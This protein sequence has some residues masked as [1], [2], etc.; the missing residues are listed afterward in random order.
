MSNNFLDAYELK[1]RVAPGLILALPLIAD[2]VYAVPNLSNWPIFTTGSLCSVALLYGLSQVVRGRGEDIEPEL[3]AA[4]GGT[5]STRV[6]RH[7]D[8]TFTEDLKA[9]ISQALTK[10]FGAQ[11]LTRQEESSNGV[12]AD[13][14]I[15]DA[16][17]QVR[18]F[19]RERDPNGL[20]FKHNMEYGFCRNLLACRWLWVLIA[21]AST[22]FAVIYSWK[23]GGNVFNFASTIGAL[24]LICAVYVGWLL[25]PG[26]TKRV[27]DGYA[28]AAWTAFL[29]MAGKESQAT[30][31]SIPGEKQDDVIEA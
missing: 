24:S 18:Q 27:A 2:A 20:W 26:A 10:A 5:P 4:W 31:T 25:L 13:K 8:N 28:E 23:T 1:A 22:A 9:S 7:R 30:A 17:R 3:W 29:S 15:A 19:L 21:L 12:R 16:F 11:L 14:V 6:M